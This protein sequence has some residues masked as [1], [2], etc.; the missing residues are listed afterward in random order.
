[1]GLRVPLDEARAVLR[2]AAQDDAIA[3][4]SWAQRI[5]AFSDLIRDGDYPATHV[6]FLGTAILAK[7]VR[8]EVD[9]LAI[10]E[11]AGPT[12]YSARSLCHGALVPEALPLGFD[13]GVRGR[14]PLNNQPYFREQRVSPNMPMRSSARPVLDALL[15]LLN[16]LANVSSAADALPILAAFI[17]VRR[18]H[19]PQA[20]RPVVVEGDVDPAWLAPQIAGFV[21]ARSEGGRRAQA[22]AA[23][24]LD[25]FAGPERVEAGRINDPD[26]H[27]PGDV[28][29]RAADGGWSKVLEVRDKPVS[30]SDLLA[31][32]GKCAEAGAREALLLS[33]S[34]TTVPDVQAATRWAAERGV[35]LTVYDGWPSFVREALLWAEAPSP[36][37]AATVLEHIQQ[38]LA[39]VEASADASSSWGAICKTA[40]RGDA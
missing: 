6:A 2:A 7:A 30:P 29:V 32:V 10:K 12:A 16:G 20:F 25:V 37:A 11:A 33:V 13:L 14:E 40:A 38:R 24:L 39:E 21:A 27:L 1:M 15:D 9:V 17:A 5:K 31:F 3:D 26:R 36:T 23:G 28:G 4:P 35:A 22:A 34:G 19:V 8:P 18:G